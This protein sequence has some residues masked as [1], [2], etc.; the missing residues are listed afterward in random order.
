MGISQCFPDVII[1]PE[2]ADFEQIEVR[3]AEPVWW[4]QRL[5]LP[6]SDT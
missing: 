2:H 4:D 6:T 5:F 3:T 1:N